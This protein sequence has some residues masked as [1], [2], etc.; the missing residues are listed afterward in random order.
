MVRKLQ[1]LF[2][3]LLFLIHYDLIP[4]S[5]ANSSPKRP[6]KPITSVYEHENMLPAIKEGTELQSLTS[7][8]GTKNFDYNRV[9]QWNGSV[10][11][12][13]MEGNPYKFNTKYMKKAEKLLNVVKPKNPSLTPSL[14]NTHLTITSL[15]YIDE[16]QATV[17]GNLQNIYVKNDGDGEKK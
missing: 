11:K 2:I 8:N 14:D 7:P 9:A 5:S 16:Y 12:S 3:P 1:Q 17:N 6:K 15:N 10:P 4:D 13:A